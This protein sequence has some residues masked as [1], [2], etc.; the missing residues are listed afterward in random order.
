L[1]AGWGRV[2]QRDFA[3][4]LEHLAVRRPSGNKV[5]AE[6]SIGCPEILDRAVVSAERAF[7]KT[8]WA[9]GRS[10]RIL[11]RWADLIEGHA[12][13]LGSIEAV[14]CTRPIREICI[15]DKLLDAKPTTI[16]G[17]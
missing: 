1:F 17:R 16:F 9:T 2:F 5:Y 14:G 10:A 4:A 7:R 6:L 11:R 15:R 12:I 13:E 3:A 8:S